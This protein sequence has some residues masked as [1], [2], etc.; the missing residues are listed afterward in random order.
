MD[1]WSSIFG[2]R[3]SETVAKVEELILDPLNEANQVIRRGNEKRALHLLERAPQDDLVAKCLLGMFYEFGVECD[4][5]YLKAEQLYEQS[6]T[7][8]D[9]SKCR[10]HDFRL[11]GRPCIKLNQKEAKKYKIKSLNWL[12]NLAQSW[13]PAQ[14]AYAYCLQEGL[15]GGEKDLEKAKEYYGKAADGGLLLARTKLA[16]LM[17]DDKKMADLL[18]SEAIMVDPR[19]LV[20]LALL[21]MD[22][23]NQEA[24]DYLRVAVKRKD[25]LGYYHL[26][27]YYADELHD[28]HVAEQYFRLA[29]SCGHVPS[30]L[31]MH[32]FLVKTDR[33]EEA[34]KFLDMAA[35]QGNPN[36]QYEMGNRLFEKEETTAI[37]FKWLL[38]AAE[39]DHVKAINIVGSAYAKGTAP[40]GANED[41]AFQWFERGFN[42]ND[43]EATC[44]LGVCYLYGKGCCRST[45]RG[46]ELIESAFLEGK[47][48][49]AAIYLARCHL[50]GQSV[51]ESRE[52]ALYWLQRAVNEYKSPRA[53]ALFENKNL[54]ESKDCTNVLAL[55]RLCLFSFFVTPAEVTKAR[56][57]YIEAALMENKTAIAELDDNFHELVA[58]SDDVFCA[59]VEI[60]GPSSM[61]EFAKSLHH[62]SE[63]WEPTYALAQRVCM[64]SL[65][66]GIPG[67]PLLDR[68]SRL[69]IGY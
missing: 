38:A 36:A 48:S 50:L 1:F 40:G 5:D 68:R 34:I 25:V 63:N 18:L 35:E 67:G 22:E 61:I 9:L 24:V 8:V 15:G 2:E 43:A 57:L 28:S 49:E 59:D 33:Q 69:Q 47:Y 51:G 6:K 17:W 26:A 4:V 29:A 58:C 37:G 52:Q 3:K 45:M 31:R 54:D 64:A 56:D 46:Y 66:D 7:A 12:K 60:G 65:K 42:L 53:Q 41:L 21:V 10:L 20:H 62:Q 14:Y 27:V 32:E 23:D 11:N 13:A 55:A 16:L 39:Q 44:H 30:Q 19:A